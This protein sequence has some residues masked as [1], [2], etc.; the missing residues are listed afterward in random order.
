RGTVITGKLERG[1]LKRGDKIEIVG[2]DRE[3]LKSVVSGL[4]SFR[5]TV[6]QAEPGDQ[7]GVLLRGLGP[8]DVR[9]GCVLLPQ[10]HKT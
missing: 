10:G 9:R 4:E 1:T 3:N 2:C 6:E 8:R 7:L 5:K